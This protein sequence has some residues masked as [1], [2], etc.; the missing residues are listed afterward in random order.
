MVARFCAGLGAAVMLYCAWLTFQ[1]LQFF[2]ADLSP[3]LGIPKGVIITA[4][5]FSLLG[6]AATLIAA[7]FRR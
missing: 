2:G 7:L 5:L 4:V 1:Y 3:V 6:L